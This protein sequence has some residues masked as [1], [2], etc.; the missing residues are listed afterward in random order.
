MRPIFR[1]TLAAALVMFVQ[2]DAGA[3]SLRFCTTYAQ[4]AME[5]AQANADNNCNL[6]GQRYANNR[7]THLQWCLSQDE[8][9]V[10]EEN[11]KRW[12]QVNAC[13]DC[14]AYARQAADDAHKN[15]EYGCG[16]SGPA[17]GENADG[18]FAWCLNSRIDAHGSDF[19][20]AINFI[21]AERQNRRNKVEQCKAQFSQ[22]E[23]AACKVFADR[24]LGQAK[25]ARSQAATR[26]A[27]ADTIRNGDW[28]EDWD[29]YFG[30]CLHDMREA[31]RGSAAWEHQAR[32]NFVL[33]QLAERTR[34][35]QRQLSSSCGV[36]ASLGKNK[37]PNPAVGFEPAPGSGCLNPFTRQIVPCGQLVGKVE[38]DKGGG[39]PCTAADRR[40]CGI[41][42]QKE[43]GKA[44]ASMSKANT[45]AAAGKSKIRQANPGSAGASTAKANATAPLTIKPRGPAAIDRLRIGSDEAVSPG[46]PAGGGGTVRARP[47]PVAS[48][49]GG[50]GAGG[51]AAG[52][53]T[54]YS[55][56]TGS[57]GSFGGTSSGGLPRG[58]NSGTR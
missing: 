23:L 18:H 56:G 39:G 22:D 55:A 53:A 27:C 28:H 54:T 43:L 13:T 51:S 6:S 40:G 10:N 26:E 7:E 4:S 31:T 24:A 17:W 45:G 52:S 49:S 57:S 34:N 5:A 50:A 44:G 21:N 1:L 3:A 19:T 48:P 47:A 35:R 58:S 37:R 12:R 14:R 32:I 16:F 11:G 42:S 25:T 9:D 33:Q 30:Q 36:V 20:R 2:D 8:D 38:V 29:G 46:V 41:H 15:A